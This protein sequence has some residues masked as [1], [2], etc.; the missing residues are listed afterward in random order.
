[1]QKKL[2]EIEEARAVSA[3]QLQRLRNVLLH[4]L[5]RT[6]MS[7]T[8]AHAHRRVLISSFV[9]ALSFIAWEGEG[10][11]VRGRPRQRRSRRRRRRRR[12]VLA[13]SCLPPLHRNGGS[14]VHLPQPPPCLLLAR[15]DPTAAA[16]KRAAEEVA[17]KLAMEKMDYPDRVALYFKVRGLSFVL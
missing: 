8:E 5:G 6:L 3:A 10:R 9:L 15:Q 11:R 13:R 7:K 17:K 12:C 1:M 14:L 4:V 16:F 2:K